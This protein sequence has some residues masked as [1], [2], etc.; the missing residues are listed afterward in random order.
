VT[1]AG[2]SEDFV[3]AFYR[4]QGRQSLRVGGDE[5]VLQRL[6]DWSDLD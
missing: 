1:V 3:L 2:T 5:L 4:R 6:L